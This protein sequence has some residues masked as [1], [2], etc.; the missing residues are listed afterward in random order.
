VHTGVKSAGW[1]NS[2]TQL[3]VYWSGKRISPWV[4]TA[5]K[6]GALSPM[7]GRD[8]IGAWFWFS[9]VFPPDSMPEKILL[10]IT[11]INKYC[12]GKSARIHEMPGRRM[13]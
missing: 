9:I 7:R 2:I 12:Q 5:L 3:P 6:A 1:L 10:I 8:T 4:V 11:I 13:E